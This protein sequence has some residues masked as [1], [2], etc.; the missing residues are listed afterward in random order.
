MFRI[1]RDSLRT[2]EHGRRFL[3]SHGE[4]TILSELRPAYRDLA[5]NKRAAENG[6]TVHCGDGWW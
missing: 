1:L 6:R 4:G 2:M 3:H 5:S